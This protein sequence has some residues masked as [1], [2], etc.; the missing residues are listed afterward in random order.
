MIHRRVWCNREAVELV[1]PEWVDWFI[2][3]R[4]LTSIGDAPP[5]ELEAQYYANKAELAIAA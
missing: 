5:A 2:Y 1:I 4:L 3:R